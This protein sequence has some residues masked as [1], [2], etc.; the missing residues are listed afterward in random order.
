MLRLFVRCFCAL[1]TSEHRGAALCER[2]RSVWWRAF[3]HLHAYVRRIRTAT[4]FSRSL[5]DWTSW[6]QP[7][8]APRRRVHRTVS[9]IRAQQTCHTQYQVQARISTTRINY[10]IMRV[11]PCRMIQRSL[12]F[13]PETRHSSRIFAGGSSIGSSVSLNVPQCAAAI[14]RRLPLCAADS[15]T[16]AF[17][18]SSGFI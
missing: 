2:L 6:L 18:L 17:M 14:T 15:S 7:W 11:S 8:D 9:K 13:M 5:N 4:S 10:L 1:R 16:T 3:S 12:L